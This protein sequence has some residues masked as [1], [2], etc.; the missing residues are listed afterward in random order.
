MY[1]HLILQQAYEGT[2]MSTWHKMKSVVSKYLF[3][4]LRRSFAFVTQAGVQWHYL[5]SLQLPPP[6]SI[7]PP[8]LAS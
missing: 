6:G 8:T 2:G 7:D 4:F 3:F 1:S 5:G